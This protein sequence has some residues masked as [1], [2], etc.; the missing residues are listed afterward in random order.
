VTSRLTNRVVYVNAAAGTGIGAAVVHRLLAED[1]IVVATDVSERRVARL[2]EDLGKT[3]GALDDGRILTRAVDAT[4]EHAVVA[5][6]SEV[7]ER[8]GHIDVL[9]NNV[10]LNRLSP[11]REMALETWMT[12]LN[13]CLTSHFL[14]IRAAW[15]LLAAAD[16][17]SVVNVSSLA[18]V[19]PTVFGESAYAAAKAGVLGLT[20][21]VAVEGAAEGIRCNAVMPGLIWNDNLTR[22]V[23]PDYLEAYRSK[24][25]FGRD[26]EPEEVADV[27]LFLASDASRHVTGEVIKVAAWL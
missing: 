12:V 17:P 21:A 14:H 13:T 1:A 4:D 7:G 2:Q 15:P 19:S 20:K 25:P 27:V 5:V 10:G 16:A 6:F 3:F 9:V 11:L 26:G 18:A 8:F 24:R 23:A 22:A